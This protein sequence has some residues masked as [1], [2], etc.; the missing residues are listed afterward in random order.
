MPSVKA[1]QG[2]H[3]RV[4]PGLDFDKTGHRSRHELRVDNRSIQEIDVVGDQDQ[5]SFLRHVG[6]LAG[7]DAA[8]QL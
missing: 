6:Q 3:K 2:A 7:V 1:E 8:Q 5:R 4:I